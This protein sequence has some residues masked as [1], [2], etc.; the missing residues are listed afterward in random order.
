MWQ[1]YV[2]WAKQNLIDLK[3]AHLQTKY[4]EQKLGLGNLHFMHAS[5]RKYLDSVL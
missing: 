2:E 4:R 5:H 3:Q 1:D